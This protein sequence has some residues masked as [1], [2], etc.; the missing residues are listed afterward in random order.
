MTSPPFPDARTWSHDNFAAVD[1]KDRRRTRRLLET[2]QQI[3]QKP[4][5]SLPS[6]FSWNPLRG[7]YR[8][9]NRPEATHAAVTAPHFAATR[10]R[11]QEASDPVL[12]LH[13]TTELDFT[14]H[15]ALKGTGP[16]GG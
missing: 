4:E 7:V 9:C 5:G 3:A 13:D 10:S 8:L 15:K 16:V 14:T 12:I 1:L 2:A 6:K 11:M